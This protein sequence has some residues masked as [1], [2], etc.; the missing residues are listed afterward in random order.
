M[1]RHVSFA[2]LRVLG[3]VCR[4]QVPL[5][6]D[7]ERSHTL[8]CLSINVSAWGSFRMSANSCLQDNTAAKETQEKVYNGQAGPK[9]TRLSTVVF[10]QE[11]E[12]RN[13]AH[14]QFKMAV[15]QLRLL[16]KL[17]L[18]RMHRILGSKHDSEWLDKSRCRWFSRVPRFIS[19]WT[20]WS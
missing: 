17:S 4:R 12:R 16:H 20:S 1:R 11:I 5:I 9:R 10:N 19:K 15:I 7:C 3:R 8:K 2:A 18:R 6:D 13:A 14:T